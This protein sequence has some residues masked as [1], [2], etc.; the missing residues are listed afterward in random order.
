MCQEHIHEASLQINQFSM[1]PLRIGQGYGVLGTA[2][3]SSLRSAVLHV[4]TPLEMFCASL[5][6]HEEGNPRQMRRRCSQ[7]QA[8]KGI[9]TSPDPRCKARAESLARFSSN[10]IVFQDAPKCTLTD[11][12]GQVPHCRRKEHSRPIRISN[13][14]FQPSVV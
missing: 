6:E 7:S 1:C 10:H 11:G 13:V 12:T 4:P 8:W 14:L 2:N 9:P 3:F 5:E